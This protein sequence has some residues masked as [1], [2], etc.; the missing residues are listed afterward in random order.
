MR[1]LAEGE[2]DTLPEAEREKALRSDEILETALR[3]FDTFGAERLPV[4]DPHDR[5]KIVGWADQVR[6]LH[7]F[8]KELI[9]ASVEEHR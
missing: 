3:K 4:V 7:L 5:S 2:S 6:A 9:A 1:P 8:N